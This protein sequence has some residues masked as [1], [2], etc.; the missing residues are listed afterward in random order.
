M[1]K[2]CARILSE[3]TRDTVDKAVATPEVTE[4]DWN[5]WID[6]KCF[7]NDTLI[8]NSVKITEKVK[9]C[10]GYTLVESDKTSTPEQLLDRICNTIKD[11]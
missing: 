5:E 4:D 1:E 3:T 7:F 6:D 9:E 11:L 10:L 2:Q 8:D